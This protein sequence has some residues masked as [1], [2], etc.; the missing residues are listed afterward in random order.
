MISNWTLRRNRLEI[1]LE[2][3]RLPEHLRKVVLATLRWIWD[4]F[5]AAGDLPTPS[6]LG[7]RSIWRFFHRISIPNPRS[8]TSDPPKKVKWDSKNHQKTSKI[9]KN[10]FFSILFE[11]TSIVTLLTPYHSEKPKNAF[12]PLSEQFSAVRR[13][14][15][16]QR[17]TRNHEMSYQEHTRNKFGK[18]DFWDFFY[19]FGYFLGLGDIWFLAQPWRLGIRLTAEN[20]PG[21]R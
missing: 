8:E 7:E 20:C 19:F 21:E 13:I 1:A 12:L 10:L 18:I 6:E 15:K 3:P 5:H 16:H 4:G 9:M 14:T 11:I 17:R 2:A